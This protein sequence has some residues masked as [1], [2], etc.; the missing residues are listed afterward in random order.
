VRKSDVCVCVQN[1]QSAL[2]QGEDKGSVV[3]VSVTVRIVAAAASVACRQ[4]LCVCVCVCVC[5]N[6]GG[7][8]W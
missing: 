4:V 5:L 3:K 7:A 8:D 6:A 2:C 1:K